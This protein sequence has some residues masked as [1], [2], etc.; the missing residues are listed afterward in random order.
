LLFY[1]ELEMGIPAYFSYIIKNHVHILKS[2]LN[3]RSSN[4]VFDNLYMDCNSIVY[5]AY[6]DLLLVDNNPSFD[7]IIE[8]TVKYIEVI[9][10][11]IQPR[12]TVFIAFDG[13]APLAKM[14]QQKLRR[15]RTLL[16][17]QDDTKKTFNTT[18]ITP[19]TKFMK[20]LSSTMYRTFNKYIVSG[21]DKAGEGEHKIMEHIRNNSSPDDT[22]AL[23]GLDSDLIM[24]A[25]NHVHYTRN[26]FI[27][28]EAQEYFQSKMPIQF[29]HKKE[30]Y[31]IDTHDL[32][33]SIQNEL[34]SNTIQAVYDYVFLCF[35]LGNDF[36]PHF[37]SLSLRTH[38]IQVLIDVYN[39][40]PIK[41][42]QIV[43]N[44]SHIEWGSV[45]I[46]LKLLAKHEKEFL[47]Q[48]YAHREKQ[49]KRYYPETTEDDR[50]K[51]LS[52]APS[53]LRG[54]EL[55]ICP[56]ESGWETRYYKALFHKKTINDEFVKR[57]CINYMEGLE[58][59]FEYYTSGAKNP[60]W[61]Y[62]YHYPPLF[63]DLY[64][65]C[66]E[67]NLRFMKEPASPYTEQEQLE[68]ILPNKQL[69]DEGLIDTIQTQQV[70]YIWPFCK[71]LWE[72][73]LVYH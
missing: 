40:L 67:M 34:R 60:R 32:M 52:N 35:L 16:T 47:L 72:A 49:S 7:L 64:R 61:K 37:P 58:W 25:I 15:Y 22:C 14:E 69:Y 26:I 17:N 24:L 54:E 66:P 57:V 44:H 2:L 41:S 1:I 65:Y 59:V 38:G 10:E 19:G 55:Y 31:F 6:R 21:S 33:N 48:E 8:T 3:I 39:N 28:R 46:F 36:L 29:T 71:Y 51:A 27:F 42:K 30:P 20:Q 23:Y 9:I 53:I 70:D 56:S 5:D 18:M 11:C 43:I 68:Y 13:V 4:T 45:R 12:K 50:E 62:N 63:R 73:K